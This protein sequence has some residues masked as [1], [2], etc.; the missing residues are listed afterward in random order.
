MFST[1]PWRGIVSRDFDT[2][3]FCFKKSIWIPNEQAETIFMKLR[4]PRS[5]GHWTMLIGLRG[6]G[7]LVVIENMSAQS[8]TMSTSVRVVSN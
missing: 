6:L 5:H 4:S 1:C 8:V 3:N 7:V 2:F